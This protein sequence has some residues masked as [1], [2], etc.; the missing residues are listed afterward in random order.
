[1]AIHTSEEEAAQTQED[2]DN[3]YPENCGIICHDYR[4][5]IYIIMIN[6]I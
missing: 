1:L 6:L 4:Y 2:N 3:N 5:Y